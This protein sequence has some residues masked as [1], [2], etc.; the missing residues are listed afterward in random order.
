MT[1]TTHTQDPH[2]AELLACAAE[3]DLAERMAAARKFELAADWAAAHPAPVQGS[4]VDEAGE[5]VLYGDRPVALAGEGAPG[6]S[7]FAVA[8]FAAAC[9]MTAHQGRA[10]LGAALEAKHRLPRIWARTLTGQ[11]AVW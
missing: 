10:F 2:L 3:A 8:E 6:M 7:E 11:I 1:S 9:G 5:L 4:V